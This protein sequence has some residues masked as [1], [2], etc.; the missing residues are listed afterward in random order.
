MADF[1]GDARKTK[2]FIGIVLDV[3]RGALSTSGVAGHVL[4]ETRTAGSTS[5]GVRTLGCFF[6]GRADFTSDAVVAE[7]ITWTWATLGQAF[8]WRNFIPGATCAR[9]IQ[10]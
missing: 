8:D 7:C 1:P 3:S 6:P 4:V 5:G 10:I 9:S 2:R